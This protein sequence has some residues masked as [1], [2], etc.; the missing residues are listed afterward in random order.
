MAADFSLF[1]HGSARGGPHVPRTPLRWAAALRSATWSGS[2]VRMDGRSQRQCLRGYLC[3]SNSTLSVPIRTHPY[4]PACTQVAVGTG[5]SCPQST[6]PAPNQRCKAFIS[7]ASGAPH[8][9]PWSPSGDTYS[10]PACSHRTT[11]QGVHKPRKRRT[12]P[13]TLVAVRRHIL[14]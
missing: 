13:T 10:S 1:C 5:D 2:F 11:P 6:P 8:Q 3:T 4:R 7:R 14:Q 12:T 9:L